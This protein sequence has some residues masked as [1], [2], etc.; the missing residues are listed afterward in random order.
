M[1]DEVLKLKSDLQQLKRGK[2]SLEAKYTNAHDN[3]SREFYSWKRAQEKK[4]KGLTDRLERLTVW[5]LEHLKH[6]EEELKERQEHFDLKHGKIWK[7][8]EGDQELRRVKDE[9]KHVEGQLRLCELR[10]SCSVE[11]PCR[12]EALCGM[13]ERKHGGDLTKSVEQG[14]WWQ[15][16]FWRGKQY[17]GRVSFI[18]D[19]VAIALFHLTKVFDERWFKSQLTLEPH[20]QHYLVSLLQGF[21]VTEALIELGIDLAIAEKVRD[22]VGLIRRLK[23]PNE[24]FT[25]RFELEILTSLRRDFQD[26]QS[27]PQLP[28]GGRADAVITTRGGQ[29]YFEIT[30]LQ[31]PFKLAIEIP[32]V[33]ER[34]RKE[35]EKALIDRPWKIRV[36]LLSFPKNSEIRH[37]AD[38]L[39]RI[40]ST[41]A[42]LRWAWVEV[43]ISRKR[44]T[45]K[46]TEGAVAQVA[47]PPFS[48]GERMS[49]KAIAKIK[50]LTP[51]QPGFVIIRPTLPAVDVNV[52]GI[53]I[54]EALKDWK[55]PSLMGVLVVTE[56]LGQ[57]RRVVYLFRNPYMDKRHD[58]M[59]NQV[60]SNWRFRFGSVAYSFF[61]DRVSPAHMIVSKGD[62]I[63]EECR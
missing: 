58:R 1:E 27:E 39:K 19:E 3:L 37:L 13:P 40:K 20:K 18:D 28:T 8:Y 48:D 15:H 54:R 6:L 34:V 30:F 43:D 7:R 62:A 55:R 16:L 50:Q 14:R 24:Y 46:V 12:I 29:V 36:T 47:G 61:K 63:L 44:L 31:P 23:G 33:I 42:S 41:P 49:D 56:A 9:I 4:I 10:E 52:V 45:E 59:L 26:V 32:S 35:I 21:N 53:E 25:A 11:V 22:S 17:M 38:E 51:S 2:E 5:E 57:E 60:L